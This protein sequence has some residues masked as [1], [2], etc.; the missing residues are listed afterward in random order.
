[1]KNWNELGMAVWTLVKVPTNAELTEVYDLYE[2][3]KF[4]EVL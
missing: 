3:A 1:M 2:K 4:A